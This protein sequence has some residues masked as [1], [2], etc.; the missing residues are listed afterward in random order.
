MIAMGVIMILIIICTVIVAAQ[1][2][3]NGGNWIFWVILGLVEGVMTY[4]IF[5]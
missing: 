2:K 4:F 5:R 3:E 1:T